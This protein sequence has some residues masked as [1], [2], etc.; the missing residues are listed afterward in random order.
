MAV[1]RLHHF[2]SRLNRYPWRLFSVEQYIRQSIFYAAVALERLFA[3]AFNGS[4][5]T[6]GIS[7][8]QSMRRCDMRLVLPRVHLCCGELTGRM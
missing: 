5:E 8:C 2:S 6:F 3:C 1:S 7:C 4:D